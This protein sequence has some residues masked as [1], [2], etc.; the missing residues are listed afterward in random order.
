MFDHLCQREFC[1]VFQIESLVH[2]LISIVVDIKYSM[3]TRSRQ[4]KCFNHRTF[5]GC[6]TCLKTFDTMVFKHN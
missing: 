1:E 3:I 6:I 2:N 4:F 5:Y